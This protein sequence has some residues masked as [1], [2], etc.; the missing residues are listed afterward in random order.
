MTSIFFFCDTPSEI[1]YNLSSFFP[2]EPPILDFNVNDDINGLCFKFET[3]PKAAFQIFEIHSVE[4]TYTFHLQCRIL[5]TSLNKFSLS[6]D[7]PN[8]LFFAKDI[9]PDRPQKK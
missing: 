2:I 3:K 8:M 1:F 9:I 7:K 6:D 4:V 5:K